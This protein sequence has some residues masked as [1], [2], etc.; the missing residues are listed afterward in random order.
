MLAFAIAGTLFITACNKDNANTGTNGQLKL[1]L[2]DGPCDDPNV[3]AVFVTVA[4]V[5]IDGQPFI[6]FSG[7]KTI[8]L[9]AYQQGN[10]A[11]LGLSELEA[12]SYQS[13]TLVLDNQTDDAGIAPGCYVQTADNV[14]HA[15]SATATQ[16]ITATHGFV[17]NSGATTNLVIDFD[18]RKAIQ[19]QNGG[20]A[21]QFDFVGSADLAT[22]L[23]LVVKNEAA[24]MS[25][26]FQNTLVAADKVVVYVYKKG[27]FDRAVEIQSTNGVSFKNAVSST[28]VGNNGQFTL[29]FLEKGDY[30][31]HF[32][33]FKDANSDGK[34]DF[35]GTLILDSLL[36]LGNLRLTSNNT[37]QLNISVVGILP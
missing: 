23:R 8:N 27:T 29:A 17:V 30:E 6:G 13:V 18:L 37:L 20:G 4:A 5:K 1:E 14:K 31:L 11:A 7:K 3:K 36:D 26:T 15:L 25:G 28:V 16:T 21:D 35:Q 2:T 24:T 19:Y 32:A 12:G 33:A 10:V 34:L 22:A 9:L